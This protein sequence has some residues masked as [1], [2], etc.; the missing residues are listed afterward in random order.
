MPRNYNLYLEDILVA[1]DKIIH[2]TKDFSFDD[3]KNDEKTQL[4]I[5]RLLEIIGEAAG[6]L[7]KEEIPRN[8]Y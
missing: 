7:P 3:F 8:I 4:A 1:T 5:L 2:F 6:K